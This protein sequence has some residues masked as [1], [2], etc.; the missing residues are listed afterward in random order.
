LP[1]VAADNDDRTVLVQWPAADGALPPGGGARLVIAVPVAIEPAV[2]VPSLTS[3]T[4]Q[5]AQKAL[6]AVGLAL[7]KVSFVQKQQIPID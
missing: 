3:L 6:E 5:E 2:E 1:T 4:Q 7:G